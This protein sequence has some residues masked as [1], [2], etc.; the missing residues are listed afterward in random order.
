M[1]TTTDRT[2]QDQKDAR[3]FLTAWL[4]DPESKEAALLGYAGTGKTW[5]TGDWLESVLTNDRNGDDSQ[6]AEEVCIAAP[7]HKALDVL[8]QKC[9]HLPVSF[10]TL[11][12]LL[13]LMIAKTEDGEIDK[14]FADKDERFTLLVVDEGSMVGAEFKGLI[15]KELRKGGRIGR[16][17]YVGDPA[18]LP[19]VKEELS[20]VF[21]VAH[22]F[23]LKQVVRYDSA[24]LNVATFLRQAIAEQDQFTLLDIR[25]IMAQTPTD[26]S[27]SII[28]KASMYNWAHTAVQKG[29][30]ARIVAWT[31]SAVLA[32]NNAMHALCYPDA[33]SYFAVGEKV[34]LNDAYT[35]TK[36]QGGV[37]AKED[38]TTDSLY[39]GELL[40][41]ES[42]VDADP[43]G[44]VRV[45]EVTATR[46]NGQ[47]VVVQFAPSESH[48]LA[49][50]K[51]LNEKVFGLGRGRYESPEKAAEYREV[52][53]LRRLIFRLAPFRHAY[54]N[55]VHK[56]QGSTY[57]I[58]I[59]DFGD[60]YR[61]DDRSRLMYVGVTR[62]SKYLV[63]A[64]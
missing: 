59:V 15:D 47:T 58:S 61:S 60:V 53:K 46:E 12:S 2:T 57:D 20:P 36:A 40:T 14:S 48:R 54:S 45:L 26:R 31:N 21:K 41:C 10:K 9:S 6:T 18:Q 55:T 5:L 63:L 19:P 22:Q 64:K 8:K 51:A 42:C 33:T 38:D 24:I 56:S 16:V 44:G 62:A 52:V 17:L 29:L 34:L 13:G 4:A 30:D 49:T 43:I 11:H 1:M 50:H 25:E 3:A 35:L 23:T 27:V 39:N 7:T 32:H 28:N 37:Q